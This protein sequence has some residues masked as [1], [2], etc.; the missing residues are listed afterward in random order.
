[1]VFKYIPTVHV[2][3]LILRFGGGVYGA[4][5]FI[6]FKT[7]MPYMLGEKGS[8]IDLV[9][10]LGNIVP[11]IPIGMIALRVFRGM[12]WRMALLLAV[13]TGLA[14][15]SLQVILHVGVFDVDDV[16]LNAL[17]VMLGYWIIL[18]ARRIFNRT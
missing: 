5:N 7:I 2:G 8:I 11:L 18:A 14:I 4:P 3:H 12:N 10:L 6:P 1:M 17:G 13:A 15:E 16:M 9:E